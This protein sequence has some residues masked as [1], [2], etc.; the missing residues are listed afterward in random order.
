VAVSPS[1]EHVRVR[2]ADTGSGI[3]AAEIPRIFERFYRV[4]RSRARGTGGAGLG[5]AIV[6][7]IMDLHAAKVEVE[8]APLEGAAFSFD[9]PAAR[10]QARPDA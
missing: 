6:K 8:S 7:R 10:P 4:D 2:V 9:L 3:P 1:G 5:L